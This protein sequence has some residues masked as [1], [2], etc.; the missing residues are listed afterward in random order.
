[1]ETHSTM[2]PRWNNHQQLINSLYKDHRHGRKS[3]ALISFEYLDFSEREIGV[4]GF[5]FWFT[6]RCRD[7]A[8]CAWRCTEFARSLALPWS[9]V[10]LNPPPRL[11]TTNVQRYP[12]CRP[13]MVVPQ[14]MSPSSRLF[15]DHQPG[16]PSSQLAHGKSRNEQKTIRSTQLVYPSLPGRRSR[17]EESWRYVETRNLLRVLGCKGCQQI[18]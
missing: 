2:D 11:V 16:A 1:M 18:Q 5:G 4:S 14:E 9:F 15:A 8:W 6:S 13:W 10:N 12:C 3:S 17:C 7:A